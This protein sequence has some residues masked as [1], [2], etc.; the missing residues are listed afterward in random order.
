MHDRRG[1]G[2]GLVQYRR[3]P[4][5]IA[6]DEAADHVGCDHATEEGG[7]ATRSRHAA[8]AGRAGERD[9]ERKRGEDENIHALILNLTIQTGNASKP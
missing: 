9:Y 6:A 1:V 4:R 2:I 5:S 3:R 7:A 8:G